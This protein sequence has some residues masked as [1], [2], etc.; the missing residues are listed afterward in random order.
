MVAAGATLA[1]AAV[2]VVGLRAGAGAPAAV[3]EV[4]PGAAV[5]AADAPA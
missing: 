1:A 4:A 3:G 5:R 2:A